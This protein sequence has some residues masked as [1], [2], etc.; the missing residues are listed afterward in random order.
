MMRA[1]RRE[2]SGVR[3]RDK[4]ARGSRAHPSTPQ[5]RIE[6]QIAP[7]QRDVDHRRSVTEDIQNIVHACSDGNG[8]MTIL[9][10]PNDPVAGSSEALPRARL[11]QQ[12]VQ[13]LI[14]RIKGKTNG[15]T[16]VI[17]GRNFLIHNNTRYSSNIHHV[18]SSIPLW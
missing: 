16:G 10:G 3:R 5:E 9:P 4:G 6:K 12:V 14:D 1:R 18:P 13:P 11:L 15:K 2:A 8:D 7:M 17:C